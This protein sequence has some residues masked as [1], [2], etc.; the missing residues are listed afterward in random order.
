MIEMTPEER[1]EIEEIF[2]RHVGILVEDFHHKLNIV[3]DGLQYLG[4]KIDRTAADLR[5]DIDRLDQR[6][7]RME[8]RLTG[9]E[10]RLTGVE[11]RLTGVETKLDA[12]AEDLAAHRADTEVHQSLYRVKEA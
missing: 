10:T 11:T 3:V 7:L 1:S 2:K 4:E 5:S 9:M 6:G 12:V 8:A